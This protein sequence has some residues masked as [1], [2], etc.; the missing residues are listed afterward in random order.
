MTITLIGTSPGQCWRGV[1]WCWCVPCSRFDSP[2]TP[3]QGAGK[4]VEKS[5]P[6]FLIPQRPKDSS[7]IGTGLGGFTSTIGGPNGPNGEGPRT[8]VPAVDH[9][10]YFEILPERI[11]WWLIPWVI[12]Y[13]LCPLPKPIES[14]VNGN[15][16]VRLI[17]A[18]ITRQK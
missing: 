9:V 10:R 4:I 11:F 6:S 7:S 18:R 3:I 14:N 8:I 13:P 16:W 17:E 1:W 5:A 2:H 15:I 12:L